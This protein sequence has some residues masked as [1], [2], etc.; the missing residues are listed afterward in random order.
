MVGLYIGIDVDE[1]AIGP[2]KVGND[3]WILY[4]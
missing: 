3:M 1:D 4:L 2:N